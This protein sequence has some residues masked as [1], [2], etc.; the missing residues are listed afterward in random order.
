[1]KRSVIQLAGKTF[2]VSLPSAWVKKHDIK[3]GEELDFEERE[4]GLLIRRE[5]PAHSGKITLDGRTLNKRALKFALA[6]LHKYGY[7]EIEVLYSKKE[8]LDLIEDLVKNLFVGFVV[9]DQSPK[10]CLLKSVST[11]VPSEFDATLRRA[12]LVTLSL[13]TSALENITQGNFKELNNLI[14]L[15][16][17]NNQLTNFCQ[18][19]LNKVPTTQKNLFR[20][21][22]AW[23][24]GKIADEYK[25]AC[26]Q[27]A[28]CKQPLSTD[29]LDVF[30]QV[31]EY[32]SKYYHLLYKFNIEMLNELAEERITIEEKMKILKL[33]NDHEKLLLNYLFA[34]LMKTTDFSTSFF[35]LHHQSP[36]P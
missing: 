20:Y 4:E 22:I 35:V 14:K 27:L 24:L 26:Q 13:G 7:D 12:F 30:K 29:I 3:K 5:T 36:E 8:S 32:F 28:S 16:E 11:P 34:I 6:G 2:V 25:Y 17:T 10:K 21:V 1:M 31:N 23:N 15:E 18:R 19:I 33:K 9:L